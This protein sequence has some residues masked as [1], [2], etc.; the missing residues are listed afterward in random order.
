MNWLKRL[1]YV[2]FIFLSSCEPNIYCDSTDSLDDK[3]TDNTDTLSDNSTES[4]SNVHDIV[5]NTATMDYDTD[6]YFYPNFPLGPYGFKESICWHIDKGSVIS[7]GDTIHNLCLPDSE[8]KTVCLS[9]LRKTNMLLVHIVDTNFFSYQSGSILNYSAEDILGYCNIP[10]YFVSIMIGR[11][12]NQEVVK[13]WK[14]RTKTKYP[15]LYDKDS[16]WKDR[17]QNDKWPSAYKRN[18]VFVFAVHTPDMKIWNTFIGWDFKYN[19]YA[20]SWY[21]TFCDTLSPM[22]QHIGEF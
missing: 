2:F 15:V 3:L 18:P 12:V 17:I 16:K 6:T 9:D 10:V 21:Q 5:C 8:G 4:D 14:D 13:S 22:Y 19:A 11:D 7:D 1:L 20:G